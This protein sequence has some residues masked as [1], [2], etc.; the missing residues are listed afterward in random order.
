MSAATLKIDNSLLS[1]ILKIV[2]DINSEVLLPFSNNIE[3][4][5]MDPSFSKFLTVVLSKGAYSDYEK[6]PRF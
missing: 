2:S 1:K 3:I 4:K 5:T 6:E